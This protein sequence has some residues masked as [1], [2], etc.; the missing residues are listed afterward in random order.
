VE[1]R[2][3]G[4]LE[5]VEDGCILEVPRGKQRSLLA[6]LLV[7]AD[8]PVST[9]VLIDLLWA[10]EPPANAAKTVQIYVSRLR[11]LIGTER[12]LTTPAGY[13]L[14]PAPG[15]LDLVEFRRLARAGRMALEEGRP[16][17]AA[18]L[19]ERALE[20]W[21]GDPLAE[22]R[23]E[24]FAQDE[25]RRLEEERA[26]ARADLVEAQLALGG[27]DILIPEIEAVVRERPLWERPRRQL[28]LA[29]YRA[30]RQPEALEVFQDARRLLV[31]ERGIDPSPELRD[32]QQAI[33]RQ[34]PSLQPAGSD[35]HEHKA[36]ADFVGRS[37]DL[38][39]IGDA[40]ASAA[41]G[42]GRV[43]LILGEPGIGKSRLGEEAARLAHS[44]SFEILVGRAWEA[45]GA[46][47]YWPWVQALRAHARDADPATVVAE[48]GTGAADLIHILPELRDVLP[49]MEAA[50]PEDERA[51]FRFF[52]A[53]VGFLTAAAT[54]RPL[55]VLLDDMHLADSSSLLLLRFLAR[56]VATARVVVVAAFRDADPAP[57]DALRELVAEISRERAASVRRLR[58]LAQTDVS[59]FLAAVDSDPALAAVLHARTEGNPLFV[60]ETVRLLG[61]AGPHAIP[62]TVRQAIAHRLDSMSDVCRDVLTTAS[63]LGRAFSLEALSLVVSVEKAALYEAVDEAAVAG[64]LVA[65]ANATMQF[66]FTHVLV[67]DVL[68]DALPPMQRVNLHRAAF[69]A[70][71]QLYEADLDPH[72]AE[73]AHHAI[74][75]G[76]R[77]RALQFGRGAGDRALR[78]LAYEEAGRLYA[79]TLGAAP[80]DTSARCRLLLALGRAEHLAGNAAASKAA[81]FEAAQLAD[82]AG[83]TRELAQAAAGYGGGFM[84]SRSSGDPQLVPLLERALATLDPGEVE[85][86]ARLLARLSGALRDE[87]VRTRRERLS[88][89]AIS[90]ATETGDPRALAFA[91]DGRIS[92]I[93]GPDTLSEC[94]A[95]ADQLVALG[96][97]LGDPD[98]ELHGHIHHLF[99]SVVS[100]DVVGASHALEEAAGIAAS[101]RRPIDLWQVA[102]CRGM[103]ALAAGSYDEVEE[104]LA[105]VASFGVEAQPEMAIPIHRM[106]MYLLRD[107][108][109]TFDSVDDDIAD[110]TD[111][112]DLYP[113]RAVFRCVVA[114][115]HA[116][117]DGAAAAGE[118]ERL[119]RDRFAAVPFDSEWLYA[120]SHLAETAVLL[121]DRDA[122]A[123]LYD[124]LLPWQHLNAVDPP[125]GGRGAVA[126][127]LGL[128]A[129]SLGRPEE[130]ERLLRAAAEMNAAMNAHPWLAR[131]QLD[132]TRVAGERRR[133]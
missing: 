128:L 65:T 121:G 37:E 74:A 113:S 42:C 10:A 84:S 72:L 125:E 53:A 68:Y 16:A 115:L 95:L 6:V 71:E 97:A 8:E 117:T 123:I 27:S 55:F 18:D 79:A 22:F 46:P 2:L 102:A 77:E 89:E 11:K 58:G 81:F 36:A 86:R 110:L 29:L 116:Q 32:L 4:L 15:E 13:A 33:L 90:L 70:L 78:L 23:F 126:R 25:I 127:Y 26:G 21:R 114:Y 98:R 39:H 104:T 103:L 64:L 133:T 51:R 75:A 91:L 48:A 108:R 1:F 105:Q 43:V 31:E 57:D 92:A 41:D 44:R 99:A 35:A 124:L 61:E 14:R 60:A 83:L 3:L 132:L 63:V 76:D 69:D 54:R 87:P 30:G 56:E 24:P 82:D 49:D 112:A 100:G 5:V 106:Q 20:R 38:A 59:A 28:M 120:L 45:G 52:Q 129:E 7:H 73:L 40:I 130:A 94:L 67:R 80:S 17:N 85:L 131:T 111:L 47:A 88:E 96:R 9:D 118:L 119:A 12:V 66:Q 101:L 19:L 50:V 34:D 93:Q 62:E 107:Q 122:A 109:T